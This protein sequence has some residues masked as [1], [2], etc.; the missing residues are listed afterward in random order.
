MFLIDLNFEIAGVL[1]SLLMISMI[2]GI[3]KLFGTR[4]EAHHFCVWIHPWTERVIHFDDSAAALRGH[5]RNCRIAL[6]T[7][8]RPGWAWPLQNMPKIHTNLPQ[9][10]AYTSGH[11]KSQFTFVFSF[12]FSSP[13]ICSIREISPGR[14]ACYA[15]SQKHEFQLFCEDREGMDVW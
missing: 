9:R 14:I 8:D 5:T 4:I 2:G 1:F 6:S 15:P 10:S 13:E 12:M 7:S 3:Y 11:H